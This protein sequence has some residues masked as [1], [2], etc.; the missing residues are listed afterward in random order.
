MADEQK[1]ACWGRST[2][3]G[4]LMTLFFHVAY[5]FLFK[6][7]GLELPLIPDAG[8]SPAIAMVG[9]MVVLSALFSTLLRY[10]IFGPLYSREA[11]AT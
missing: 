4:I 9:G 2:L 11:S 5:G 1:H 7:Y 6:A 3:V 10:T 8:G